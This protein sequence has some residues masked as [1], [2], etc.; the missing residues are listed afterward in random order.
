MVVPA[1]PTLTHT[2]ALLPVRK[3]WLQ[4]VRAA[5]VVPAGS[6]M[7]RTRTHLQ[8]SPHRMANYPDWWDLAVLPAPSFSDRGQIG[9]KE[10][11]CL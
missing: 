6:Q 10:V 2:V 3:R 11:G 1:R 4:C 5:P 8:R 7:G 9:S